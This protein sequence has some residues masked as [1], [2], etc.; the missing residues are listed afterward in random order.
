MPGKKRATLEDADD[1]ASDSPVTSSKR[2]RTEC[3]AQENGRTKK[4]AK[5]KGTARTSNDESDD[6][7]GDDDVELD[8]EIEGETQEDREEKEKQLEA[9]YYEQIMASVKARESSRGVSSYTPPPSPMSNLF[10]LTAC[11]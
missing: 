11:C 3:L 6:D 9:M 8:I 5:G 7:E 4:S 10:S 1:S 2:P